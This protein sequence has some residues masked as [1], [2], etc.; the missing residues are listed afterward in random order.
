MV[1]KSH[2]NHSRLYDAEINF[3]SR[4]IDLIVV[5]G[6]LW[7]A[8]LVLSEQWDNDQTVSSITGGAFFYISA[9]IL[10]LYKNRRGLNI[11]GIIK[12]VWLAWF[13]AFTLLLLIAFA[14]KTSAEHSRRVMMTWAFLSPILLTV[15]RLGFEMFSQEAHRR[16]FDLRSAAIVGFTPLGK[17][18]AS[19]IGQS[20]WMGLELLGFYDDRGRERLEGLGVDDFT[21]CG[22]FQDLVEAAKEG[23]VDHVYVALPPRAEPR[24]AEL[25]K[26]L[27]DTTASV[28]LV[29]DFGGF[30]LL[31]AQWSTIGDIPVMSVVEHPFYGV[32]GLLKRLEDIFIGSI[33]LS[34]IAIPMAI[35]SIGVKLSSPGPVFFKQR[36]YGLN[37]E[38]VSVLKF[39]SMT[40]CEDGEQVVQATKND[41][42][43]TKFGGFLR[44]T[45]LDELPQ[46]LQVVGGT[47]SIVGPRPH[48]VSHNETYR[49]QIKGYMLRHKVKPGITGWAQVNGWRG[50]TDTLEKMEKRVEYD[51]D[52]I[53]GWHIG[54][55]LRIIFLTI[56]QVFFGHKNAY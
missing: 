16:G 32:D 34:I 26:R 14:S 18:L 47:M 55:D 28:H 30:D 4:L 25:V 36:R 24:I 5:G 7:I 35:I 3:I 6:S 13:V 52:Y 54:F 10:G 45:S 9:Q 53:R 1:G 27:A 49:S 33:I 42:R 15:W 38:V 39:R 29:Y 41:Q 20:P 12:R 2:G 23:D 43:I 46:F 11:T 56:K 40:V 17:Q 22:R 37:G 50:E 8:S 21:I 51:L 44:R 48:A 19:R 31:R